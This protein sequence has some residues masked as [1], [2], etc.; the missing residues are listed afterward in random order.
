MR[1]IQVAHVLTHTVQIKT[2]EKIGE[3]MVKKPYFMRDKY[4]WTER[5]FLY[6]INPNKL[7]GNIYS[8]NQFEK[9]MKEIASDMKIEDWEYDRHDVAIDLANSYTDVYKLNRY[10]ICLA[11]MEHT[12]KNVMDIRGVRDLRKRSLK[13]AKRKFDIEIYDK[14]L[15]SKGKEPYT[16]CEFRFKL[17]DEWHHTRLLKLLCNTLERF[18]THIKELDKERV[19]VLYKKWCEEKTVRKVMSINEFYRK[20]SDEIF[21]V[22]ISRNLYNKITDT[23]DKYEQWIKNYRR[24]SDIQFISRKTFRSYIKILTR[25]VKQYSKS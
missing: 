10:L 20:Y 21:T 14:N 23:T 4:K 24:Y 8:Y 7:H 15:E 18:E 12:T 1:E 25:A 5:G 22:E 17:L 11:S 16:R 19:E 6:P 2:K 3:D 9:T 13:L